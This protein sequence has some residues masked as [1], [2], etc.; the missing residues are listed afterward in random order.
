MPQAETKPVSGLIADPACLRL[1]GVE[2]RDQT[3]ADAAQDAGEQHTGR[4][5]VPGKAIAPPTNVP[6]TNAMMGKIW[7]ARNSIDHESKTI[8]RKLLRLG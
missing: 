7:F 5:V 1:V 4:I 3:G 6:P 8:Q 2:R